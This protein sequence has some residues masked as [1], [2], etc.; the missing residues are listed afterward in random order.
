MIVKI[1]GQ[2]YAVSDPRLGGYE[3]AVNQAHAN[4]MA[5]IRRESGFVDDL[6]RPESREERETRL[7]DDDFDRIIAIHSSPDILA[8]RAQFERYVQRELAPIMTRIR[9]V[10]A[11]ELQHL[12]VPNVYLLRTGNEGGS[13]HFH[14]VYYEAP[15][16]ILD[17]G[18]K[19]GPPNIGILYNTQTQQLGPMAEQLIDP[20][21]QWGGKGNRRMDFFEM[22]VTRTLIA[23][24][25]I[26]RYRALTPDETQLV[27]PEEFINDI[28]AEPDYLS[29][30]GSGKYWQAQQ[31][32]HPFTPPTRPAEQYIQTA[33]EQC[34]QRGLPGAI[35][36]LRNQGFFSNPEQGRTLL[37]TLLE[38]NKLDAVK[39]ILRQDLVDLTHPEHSKMLY[40]S[41]LAF[42]RSQPDYP[43]G[44]NHSLKAMQSK[45]L[46]TMAPEDLPFTLQDTCEALNLA[47]LEKM[48]ALHPDEP[49]PYAD[50]IDQVYKGAEDCHLPAG[51]TSF[52]PILAFLR[53]HELLTSTT[54]AERNVHLESSETAIVQEEELDDES[55]HRTPAASLFGQTLLALN[56]N[57]D[58]DPQEAWIMA[59]DALESKEPYQCAQAHQNINGLRAIEYQAETTD[60]DIIINIVSEVEQILLDELYAKKLEAEERSSLRR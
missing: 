46:D 37:A 10:L 38:T 53:D 12:I 13:G 7:A 22:T 43:P 11:T 45:L 15:N 14:T 28:I 49:I 50:L 19:D 56:E 27:F 51:S 25:Y 31:N 60:G 24:K 47:A 33:I 20:S 44:E 36:Q 55:I 2:D 42:S 35:T 58:I 39:E 52:T 54:H 41:A 34:T 32:G 5:Q 4:A 9:Q 3:T 30:F 18:F 23:A 59:C 57:E 1:P 6:S 26:E 8:E 40:Q 16:W 48:L 21:Q 29:T 17:S